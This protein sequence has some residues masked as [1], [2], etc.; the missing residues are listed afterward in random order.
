[1]KVF[2]PS[3]V[4]SGNT[5]RHIEKIKESLALRYNINVFLGLF[6]DKSQ[7]YSSGNAQNVLLLGT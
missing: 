5:S 3:I 6:A 4:I 7:L 2:A 1:L